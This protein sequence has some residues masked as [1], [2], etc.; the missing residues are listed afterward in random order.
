MQ[1]HRFLMPAVCCSYTL[2]HNYWPLQSSSTSSR[3]EFDSRIYQEFCHISSKSLLDGIP[4]IT[5]PEQVP[6][7]T[8]TRGARQRRAAGQLLYPA[9]ASSSSPVN[10]SSPPVA[11]PSSRTSAASPR[12]IAPPPAPHTPAVRRAALQ[13]GPALA[14]GSTTRRATRERGNPQSSAAQAAGPPVTD[15]VPLLFSQYGHAVPSRGT[16]IAEEVDL[17]SLGQPDPSQTSTTVPHQAD[18]RPILSPVSRAQTDARQTDEGVLLPEMPLTPLLERIYP[19]PLERRIPTVPSAGL[20][21]LEQDD[22]HPF[23]ETD[24]GDHSLGAMGNEFEPAHI[25]SEFQGSRNDAQVLFPELETNCF[26]FQHPSPWSFRFRRRNCTELCT[27]EICPLQPAVHNEGYYTHGVR[28]SPYPNST[29]GR[30]DPPPE[31]WQAYVR[32]MESRDNLA[33]LQLVWAF[34]YC[35]HSD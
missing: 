7:Q 34:S 8:H 4:T 23:T 20:R 24:I 15:F 9:A 22:V 10:Q 28:E 1:W 32:M 12:P 30:S 35:H 5:M 6:F 21:W 3:T 18:S 16:G 2:H 33:D 31:I 14:S 19:Q 11:A 17:A 26:N 27:S 29:F 25:F 13:Q